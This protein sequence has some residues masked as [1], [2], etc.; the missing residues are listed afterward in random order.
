M[1]LKR[2]V[3]S[4]LNNNPTAPLL[5]ESRL[6][7]LRLLEWD[8]LVQTFNSKGEFCM[9]TIHK[10]EDSKDAELRAIEQL[11]RKAEVVDLRPYRK[12]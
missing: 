10:G 3:T 7:T 9:E 12:T 8:W 1:T 4:E 6:R 2:M 5:N 11:G